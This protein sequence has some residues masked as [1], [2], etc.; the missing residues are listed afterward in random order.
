MPW[1]YA[2]FN[3]DNSPML[4]SKFVNSS[5]YVRRGGG[6]IEKKEKKRKEKKRKKEKKRQDLWAARLMIQLKLR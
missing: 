6:L 5:P 3:G 4:G 2:L 1:L